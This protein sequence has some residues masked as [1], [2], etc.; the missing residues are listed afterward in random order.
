MHWGA[1]SETGSGTVWHQQAGGEQAKGGASEDKCGPRQGKG[2]G[3]TG[4]GGS[5]E[6]SRVTRGLAALCCLL[7]EKSWGPHEQSRPAL[8]ETGLKGS[9]SSVG[10]WFF[11]DRGRSTFGDGDAFQVLN[12]GESW[13]LWVC[14]NTSSDGK[15][16]TS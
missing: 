16:T 8:L 3:P 13:N 5:I 7:I 2:C 4:R 12:L 15:L 1:P 11:G 10:S 14:L 9:G 6:A